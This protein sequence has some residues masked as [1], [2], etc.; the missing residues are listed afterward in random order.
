MRFADVVATTAEVTA[1]RARSRKVAA[2]ADLFARLDA[3]ELPVVVAILTG[4]PR[5][6]RIGIGWRT[7]AAVEAPPS[8]E[9]QLEVGDIDA[10]LDRLDSLRGAGSQAARAA[11]LRSLLGRATEDEQDLL[12][13][14]LVGEL[15][16]GALDGLVTDALAKAS[17]VQLATMRRAAMLAGDLPAV[18]TIA[19]TEGEAGLDAIGLTL[20]RPVQP[21]LAQT[22]TDVTEALALATSGN[23]GDAGSTRDASVEWKLD[24]ARI[25]V[26]RVGD[27]VR[28]YTRN[29]NDVSARLPGIVDL[30]RSLPARSFLLDGE[31]IGVGEDELPQMFQDTMSQFGRQADGAGA[32]LAARFFDILHLDGDDLIDR[33]LRDRLATLEDL[34]GPWRIPGI[35]TADPAEAQR[36]L[37]E[38]LA[39]GHEG[40]MV[41]D[42]DSAYEAGRRGGAWRKVKPVHT[43]DL[44]VIAV[45]WGSGRRQGWLSNL[46]LGAR[47]PEAPREFVMVGKT[48]KGLTDELLAWQTER[49]LELETHRTDHVLFVRPELVVEIALDGVQSST[50]Y[51]GGVALRF[52]RVRRYR[53]DKSPA[54]ADTIDAVRAMLP[55]RTIIS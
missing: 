15:R 13:R 8:P 48:F 53:A 23:G 55:G 27:D 20:L 1:T 31:A 11:E 32:G 46:H 5:Q 51:A 10:T 40:V 22:A 44:V 21:M 12:R 47:D 2:L 34:A 25:Q 28:I 38:A 14:L 7:V 30:A 45:E 3:A 18:A 43:L 35:I 17:G 49:F 52:A 33:P 26:H 54:E 37:D 19:L 9:P 4:T 36:V 24:G 39:A 41:K 42:A 29:L 6:G 16:H 50:R